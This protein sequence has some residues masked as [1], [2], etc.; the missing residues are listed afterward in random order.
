MC[1][2]AILP[3]PVMGTCAAQPLRLRV[4]GQDPNLLPKPVVREDRLHG[5]DAF[6]VENGYM[7]ISALRGGGHLGEIRLISQDLS[8]RPRA[9]VHLA[10]ALDPELPRT[11]TGPR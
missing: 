9:A 7:R 1:R 6:V 11:R 2:V 8:R 5:R 4:E 10:L 3:L